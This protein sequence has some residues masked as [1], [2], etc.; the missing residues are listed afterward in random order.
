MSAPVVAYV[1]PPP[2]PEKDD[3]HV[4]TVEEVKMQMAAA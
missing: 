2:E 3:G 1:A 4:Q